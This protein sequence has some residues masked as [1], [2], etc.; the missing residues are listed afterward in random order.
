MWSRGPRAHATVVHGCAMRHTAEARPPR[1]PGHHKLAR[2]RT[3]R[4]AS[5]RSG[6]RT[7][8]CSHAHKDAA[9]LHCPRLA[10]GCQAT[11]WPPVGV[12]TRS[13]RHCALPHLIAPRGLQRKAPAPL[14]SAR[15][16][17]ACHPATPSRGLC[18]SSTTP[19]DQQLC[20]SCHESSAV[21][22]P[23]VQA[24]GM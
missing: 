20:R 5:Q 21:V 19:G 11:F 3:D 22:P 18:G 12:A 24:F 15:A 8:Q 7:G 9:R 17:A 14:R 13:N 1:R 2:E 16:A 6:R 4:Y 23:S 10:L